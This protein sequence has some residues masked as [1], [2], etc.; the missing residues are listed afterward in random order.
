[1]LAIISQHEHLSMSISDPREPLYEY[2]SE[3]VPR[4]LLRRP[5]PSASH[6]Q[7]TSWPRSPSPLLASTLARPPLPPAKEFTEDRDTVHICGAP[8]RGRLVPLGPLLELLSTPS[9]PLLGP[10]PAPLWQC[11]CTEHTPLRWTTKGRALGPTSFA[12]HWTTQKSIRSNS[13]AS[14][15]PTKTK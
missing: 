8:C 3:Q 14:E 9:T 4:S 10:S 13:C 12:L 1:M 5:W 7:H 2:E 11:C 6:N 15:Y